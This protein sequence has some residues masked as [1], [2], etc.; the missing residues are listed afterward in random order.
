VSRRAGPGVDRPRAARYGPPPVSLPQQLRLALTRPVGEPAVRA[1]ALAH[2]AACA[3]RFDAVPPLLDLAAE[4]GAGPEALH[5]ACLQVVA[6]GGFP[7][8]IEALTL[9][10]ARRREPPPPA[11]REPAPA[12]G[13]AVW[14]SIYSD[15]AEDVLA[16]LEALAPGFPHWVLDS[17]YRRILARPGLALR[18]RELLGVAALALM[19]LPAPLGSHVRGALRNGSS[20][21]LVADILDTARVLAGPEALAVID[22]AVDRLSR[23][24]YRA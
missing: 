16:K 19:A 11:H 4:L 21:D 23:N 10:S 18:D 24:V 7:R 9:L 13:R 5:E 12:A 1:L 3:G 6:Y 20:A 8:A 14:D 22:Q 2:G 15:Q 17:A